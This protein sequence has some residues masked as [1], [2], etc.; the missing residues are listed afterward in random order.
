V[1][2]ALVEKLRLPAGDIRLTLDR[3]PVALL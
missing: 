3:D 2:R 1:A